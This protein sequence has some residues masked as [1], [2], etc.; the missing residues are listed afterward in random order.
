MMKMGW[1]RIVCPSKH[2]LYFEYDLSKPP[3]PKQMKTIKDLSI[4]WE[5]EE[6]YDSTKHKFVG[7]FLQE[8]GTEGEGVNRPYGGWMDKNLEFHPVKYQGHYLWAW[9]YLKKNHRDANFDKVYTEL[10]NRGFIRITFDGPEMNIEYILSNPPNEKQKRGLADIALEYGCD[11]I[12]DTMTKRMITGFLQESMYPKEFDRNAIGS[13]MAAAQLTTEYLLKKGITDFKII[14]GWI[15][16]GEEGD[17]W[18]LYR[19]EG[20]IKEFGDVFTHT[21]IQFK[22][23]R[24]FDP[25][26][27]Q[28]EKWGFNPEEGKIVKIKTD[29]KPE[30]YLDLCE[31]D[32]S[33]W[34]NFKKKLNENLTYSE[35]LKLTNDGEKKRGIENGREDRA[36]NVRVRSLP[37]SMD[38]NQ[39]QWNFRYK[40]S[41]ETTVT[42][43]P[44]KGAI[45]FIKGEVDSDDDAQKLE[46]KVDCQCEDFMYRFAYNDAAKGASE[47][48]PDSLNKCINQKPQPAYDYGEGLCKHLIA[49]GK[50]LSTKVESTKKSN[51]FEA[52]GDV[53]RQGPFNIEYYD[54][55]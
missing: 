14:E 43:K 1:V 55:K 47:V 22:N 49:L 26:K 25:T 18:E 44:F 41:P 42:D 15:A 45:T 31:W 53:A 10:Y 3:T 29:Y 12:Y 4:E 2:R 23:G 7:G 6:I 38:G 17:Q 28:W 50:Y 20:K 13:C 52:I 32:P 54:S 8:W 36:K 19:H 9:K 30:E 37:V 39:E 27:K 24:I 51:L 35:L 40:S 5:C 21:W 11:Q 16:F 46:C 48:G 33:N 34:K